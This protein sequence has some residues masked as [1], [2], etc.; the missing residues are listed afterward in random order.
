LPKTERAC[1]KGFAAS[2]QK[3]AAM[4]FY[5][6][7]YQ[8]KL[9]EALTP[10]FLTMTSGIHRLEKQEEQE[11]A[12][13]EAARKT[14]PDQDGAV[15]HARKQRKTLEDLTRRARRVTIRLASM[16]N[17][18]FWLSAAE[19]VAHILTDGDCLQSHNDMRIFTR[20][21]LQWALQQCKRHLKH[22]AADESIDKAHPTVQAVSF[23][24]AQHANDNEKDDQEDHASESD[25][26]F[27]KLEAITTSTNTSPDCAHRRSKL[28]SMP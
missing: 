24:V 25:G 28:S 14:A 8:G 4:D 12:E 10:L 27:D 19:L 18:C 13:A 1:I 6:T 20:R 22:E 21:T 3:A 16:A 17:R 5:I 23:Q 9:M 2:F 15:Q 7:K 11:E 26:C